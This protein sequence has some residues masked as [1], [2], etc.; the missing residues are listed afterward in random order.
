MSLLSL[1]HV[2]LRVELH[3]HFTAAQLNSFWSLF[4]YVWIFQKPMSIFNWFPKNEEVRH[5]V[6]K[7]SNTL[8]Y[9]PTNTTS[10][11]QF[12][13]IKKT[14][15]IKDEGFTKVTVYVHFYDCRTFY[16]CRIHSYQYNL[17][18]NST[19]D[20]FDFYYNA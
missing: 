8:K 20:T 7:F 2:K 18:Y 1:E 5:S 15:L 13:D 9:L 12:I 17:F 6:S 16:C 4:F 11:I 14:K 10:I 3:K 19:K